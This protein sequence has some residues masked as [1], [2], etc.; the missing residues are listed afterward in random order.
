MLF[1]SERQVEYSDKSWLATFLL[2]W[3]LGC[4]GIHRFYV[5]KVGS[6]IAQ[7]LT[8]GGLGI[9]ALVDWIIIICGNF[10]DG[11]GKVLTYK[12]L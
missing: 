1:M 11:D 3:F 2:C 12:N 10:K 7:L 4:W 6:G 5:G 9:W 8:L